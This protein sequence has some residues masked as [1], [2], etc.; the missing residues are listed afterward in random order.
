VRNMCTFACVQI[1]LL[2]FF[3]KFR[4]FCIFS[5]GILW[6]T[7]KTCPASLRFCI[8]YVLLILRSGHLK[9]K[10]LYSRA[11][12]MNRNLANNCVCFV[13]IRA[14]IIR[15]RGFG[16]FNLKGPLNHSLSRFL[17]EFILPLGWLWYA[18]C[19]IQT[20]VM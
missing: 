4:T 16:D 7:T 14:P 19:S 2:L 17:P 18:Q 6:Y 5:L 15:L 9:W 3:Y 1:W 20:H 10:S 11:L 12:W 8:V 13:V